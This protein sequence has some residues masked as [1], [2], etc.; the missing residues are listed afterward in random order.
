MGLE[1]LAG[2]GRLLLALL[3]LPELQQGLQN[4][5]TVVYGAA[6]EQGCRRGVGDEGRGLAERK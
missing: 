1:E 6:A 5:Q 4:M 2:S 3:R